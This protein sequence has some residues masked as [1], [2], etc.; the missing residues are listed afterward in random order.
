MGGVVDVGVGVV[1][2]VVSGVTVGGYSETSGLNWTVISR[3]SVAISGNTSSVGHLP[4]GLTPK[5]MKRN[6]VQYGLDSAYLFVKLG[7][8]S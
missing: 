6:D 2:T 8:P 5:I 3:G 1:T 7:Q 4:D